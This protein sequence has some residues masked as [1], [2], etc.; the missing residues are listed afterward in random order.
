M[1]SM[2]LANKKCRT[3]YD[4]HLINPLQMP[5]KSMC[6]NCCMYFNNPSKSKPQAEM[7]KQHYACMAPTTTGVQ[8]SSSITADEP[9]IIR[10]RKHV[11]KSA[12]DIQPRKQIRKSK[13][14]AAIHQELRREVEKLSVERAE[15]ILKEQQ[16][17]EENES[18][19]K[20]VDDCVKIDE[21]TQ[22]LEAARLEKEEAQQNS[23]NSRSSLRRAYEK[24]STL[25]DFYKQK[26]PA[27]AMELMVQMM[28]SRKV[29]HEDIV[30]GVLKSFLQR[31]KFLP[32]IS[33]AIVSNGD[34]LPEVSTHYQG[35][36][37]QK[38]RFKYRPWIC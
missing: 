38:L 30:N 13:G 12:V 15:S 2:R 16:L 25:V 4:L 27:V 9:Q 3:C 7:G 20:H 37:Y 22:M 28:I 29:K 11:S 5:V 31:K 1:T 33:N 32:R 26:D 21:L 23:R 34:L 8:L 14:Y 24:N 35:I 36:M 10:K 6:H 17:K 19:K 18:L